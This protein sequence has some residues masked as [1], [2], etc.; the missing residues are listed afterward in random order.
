MEMRRHRLNRAPLADAHN[1]ERHFADTA[2]TR[3]LL[4]DMYTLV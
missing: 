4:F 2:Y 3:Y 1:A